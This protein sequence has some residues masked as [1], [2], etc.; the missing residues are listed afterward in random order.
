MSGLDNYFLSLFREL[1]VRMSTAFD[2]FLVVY[3]DDIF[4]QLVTIVTRYSSPDVNESRINVRLLSFRQSIEYIFALHKNTF[5]LFNVVTRLRVMLG[6][7][8]WYM[9]LFYS[10]F[11]LNC[12]LCL[13]ESPHNFNI[14]PPSLEQCFPLDE[15]LTPAPDITDEL[16]GDINNYNV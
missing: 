16:L 9:L 8:H 12:Y 6:G 11:L 5:G 14:R 4:P 10:F 3:G 2:Q 13:H 7:L 15:I 1:N